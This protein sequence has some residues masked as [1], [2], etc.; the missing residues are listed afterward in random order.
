MK[1]PSFLPGVRSCALEFQDMHFVL[2]MEENIVCF[3]GKW[4]AKFLKSQKLV[5]NW[6]K[7]G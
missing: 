4:D 1:V 3:D 7:Q 5:G 6:K 2:S